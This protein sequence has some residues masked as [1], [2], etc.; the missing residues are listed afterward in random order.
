M[1]RLNL[2]ISIVVLV[3]VVFAVGCGRDLKTI[4]EYNDNLLLKPE[5]EAVLTTEITSSSL[6]IGDCI[7]SD[8][9]TLTDKEL[10]DSMVVTECAASTWK[11]KT[12]NSFA[13]NRNANVSKEAKIQCDR[14]YTD[15]L[16][17]WRIVNGVKAST[18]KVHCLQKR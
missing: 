9:R 4:R 11:Y 7:V 8:I 6:Q 1:K 12:L 3:V 17:W 18:T 14:G 5:G 10:N 16:F 2:I 13:V 15:T